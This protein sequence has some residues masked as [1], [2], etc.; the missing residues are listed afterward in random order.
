MERVKDS[1]R[2]ARGSFRFHP[3][4][5][6]GVSSPLQYIAHRYAIPAHYALELIE[7]M[8]MDARG[9][10][11]TTLEE[12]LL[13]LLPRRRHGRIDDDARHGSARR[14]RIR[15]RGRSWHRLCN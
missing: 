5:R 2:N 12:L 7:G 1:E 10:R 4:K 8:A 11:Y 6:A 15:K 3:A 13:L 9:M 14:A